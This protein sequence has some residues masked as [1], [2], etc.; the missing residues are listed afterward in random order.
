MMPQERPLKIWMRMRNRCHTSTMAHP[1]DKIGLL[2]MD[3]RLSFTRVLRLFSNVL[4]QQSPAVL[5]LICTA[6]AGILGV[7]D[8]LT[9]F[10]LSFALFYLVPVS[11]AA[12]MGG[13]RLGITIGA[14]SALIWQLANSLAGQQFSQPWIPYWN[15][16][17]RLGF[18]LVV[19]V[20]LATLRRTL[21]RAETLARIDPLTGALNG[22]AFAQALEREMMSFERYQRPFTLVYFDLDHFKLVNDR[23]GHTI[24][25]HL[26]QHIVTTLQANLRR[27]DSIAR[28]GGDEFALLL[29][30]TSQAQSQ[31]VVAKIQARLLKAM[32]EQQWPVTFSIGVLT[33]TVAPTSTD[34]LIRQADELMY[35]VKNTTRN[36]IT[37]ALY[38]AETNRA[39]E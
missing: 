22:R 20:L 29:A 37:Y 16:S 27:L 26:L 32:H 5:G 10:E 31:Q 23:Y 36:A 4:G 2:A 25:D 1:C 35:Q 38:R 13:Q 30:D 12:W 6:Q 17:T 14:I 11:L 15:T 34:D 28:L 24:G 18:F 39:L 9:G 19:T 7:V 21:T 3:Q 33:C 8:Y